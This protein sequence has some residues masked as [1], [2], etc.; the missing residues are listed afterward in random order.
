MKKIK[1]LAFILAC[2]MVLPVFIAC[3]NKSDEQP[4]T[5]VNAVDTSKDRLPLGV[6]SEDNGGEEFRILM[7]TT[8]TIDYAAERGG[9]V[10]SQALYDVDTKVE[11]HLSINISYTQ[12]DGNWANRATFNNRL[13]AMAMDSA[14]EYDLIMGETSASYAFALQNGLVMDLTEIDVLELDSP[15]YIADAVDSYGINGKLYGVMGDASLITYQSLHL[16]Y[17]NETMQNN[18]KL[19]APYESIKNGTWDIEEMFTMA[20]AV[21]NV[22]NGG[23]PNLGTDTFGCIAQHVAS[24]AFLQAFNIELTEKSAEDGNTYMKTSLSESYIDMYDY[25]YDKFENNPSIYYC[26]V[27]EEKD[28]GWEAFKAGRSL[29]YVG[30]FSHA[31]SFRDTEWNWSIAPMPKWDDTQENYQSAIGSQNMMFMIMKNANDSELSGKV[32]EVK[33]YYNHYE[34]V[35]AYYEDTLGYQY[36]RN[37]THIEMLE[38]IRRTGR[39]NYL[40]AMYLVM[41]PDPANLFQLDSYYRNEKVGGSASTFYTTNITSWNNTLKN[42]YKN[43]G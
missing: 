7:P 15:W 27:S 5:G 11:D 9:T 33:S 20:A 12:L 2:L 3:G 13:L 1:I 39:L 31:E 23:T 28:M 4:N 43:L 21:E 41:N 32:L 29:F 40:N 35:P 24:R 22:N 34:A 10:V 19:S 25:M 18:Y 16:V 26:T 38:L 30:F 42:L 14:S 17:V 36:G 6:A 37:Q 8:N